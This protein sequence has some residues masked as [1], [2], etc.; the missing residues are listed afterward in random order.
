[1]QDISKK[2]WGSFKDL[3]GLKRSCRIFTSAGQLSNPECLIQSPA[4]WLI[5][6]LHFHKA[7]GLH[8]WHCNSL[9]L[10]KIYCLPISA[11][12]EAIHARLWFCRKLYI[13][14]STV[15]LM[16][17]GYQYQDYNKINFD[18]LHNMQLQIM[19]MKRWQ[20]KINSL[21]AITNGESPHQSLPGAR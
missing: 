5:A 12:Q 9:N 7:Y 6:Q 14:V 8:K 21:K 19:E 20:E 17:V 10:Q 1:M 11:L 2:L 15:I 13:I 4:H 3:K 16:V 18:M